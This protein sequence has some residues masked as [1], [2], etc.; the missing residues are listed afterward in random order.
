MIFF[1]ARTPDGWAIPGIHGNW[2]ADEL[3]GNVQGSVFLIQSE[4]EALLFDTG[5]RAPGTTNSMGPTIIEKLDRDKVNL[6]YIFISHFHYD[7]TGNASELKA[8]YGAQVLCHPLDRPIIE[9]PMIITRPE[10]LDRFNISPEALLED[11]NL[12]PG[13]SLGLSDKQVIEQYW[14]FPVE[15]D[16]EVVDGDVLDVGSLKLEV[17]H[18]PG[19]SPGH[20]GLWNPATKSLYCADIVHYPTPLSPHPIGDAAAHLQTIH[21]CKQLEPHFLWEGHYL[22]AYD[23]AA[24]E[25]RLG[26]LMQMQLDTE[27]R[28]LTLLRRTPA[29]QT[30]LDLVPEVFPVKTDLNYPVSSGTGYRYAYAEACIQSHLRR[31]VALDEVRR[32]RENGS[33]AFTAVRR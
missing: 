27:A 29:P 18:L 14:N 26:H 6:K 22:S 33:I 16:R 20:I 31:L 2:G 5:N 8:R 3:D 15:V 19:H 24:V 7:H 28:L 21:R 10:N 17:V 32:E 13:Q 11:F 25:R 30:I 23:A 12:E 4:G 9:D 1:E